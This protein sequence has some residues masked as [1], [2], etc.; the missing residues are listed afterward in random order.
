MILLSPTWI[1]ARN[2][3]GNLKLY[4][5]LPCFFLGVPDS[6][7]LIAGNNTPVA[8]PRATRRLLGTKAAGK[9]MNSTMLAEESQITGVIEELS[10]IAKEKPTPPGGRGGGAHEGG[11]GRCAGGGGRS[12]VVW[13]PPACCCCCC[14]VSSLHHN[15]RRT[16][17]HETSVALPRANLPMHLCRLQ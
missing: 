10:P 14:C 12:V 1:F 8:L 15:R 7:L 17:S 11:G 3:A 16:A 2:S 5:S 4:S 6:W 13:W 9:T